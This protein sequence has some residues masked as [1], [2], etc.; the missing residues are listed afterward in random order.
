MQLNFEKKHEQAGKI[1]NS[2]VKLLPSFRMRIALVV[3]YIYKRHLLAVFNEL[4]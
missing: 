1:L 2:R 3:S 4:H